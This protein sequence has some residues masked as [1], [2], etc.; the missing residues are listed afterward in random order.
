MY[1]TPKHLLMPMALVNVLGFRCWF[2]H[3]T[4]SFTGGLFILNSVGVS[5]LM[6]SHVILSFQTDFFKIC[7]SVAIEI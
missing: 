3:F 6:F 1:E 2:F 4:P 7:E 5:L